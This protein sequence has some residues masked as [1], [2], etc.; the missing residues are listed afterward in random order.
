MIRFLSVTAVL[1]TAAAAAHAQVYVEGAY[2]PIN[3][4]NAGSTVKPGAISGVLGYE[5]NPNLAAEAYL[6]SGVKKDK[7]GTKLSNSFAVF[8]KP[9]VMVSNEVEV[10]A[11]L[12]YEKSNASIGAT[13][14][15]NSSFAYGLGGNYYMDKKTYVTASYMSHYSKDGFKINGLNIGVG[16]KF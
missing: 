9:K 3:I 13:S 12:G 16:Y 15:S 6:A 1:A 10:F 2:N 14:F 7:D 5:V 11:R 4:T 8:L